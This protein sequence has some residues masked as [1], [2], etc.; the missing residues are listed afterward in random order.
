MREGDEAHAVQRKT[1]HLR[2][3]NERGQGPGK[4]A[5]CVPGQGPPCCCLPRSSCCLTASSH[6][7]LLAAV[8]SRPNPAICPICC[9]LLPAA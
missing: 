6:P 7:Y 8:A 2:Q 3:R 4:G 5:G 1:L 9:C